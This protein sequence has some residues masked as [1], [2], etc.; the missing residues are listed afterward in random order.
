MAAWHVLGHT[1]GS[2]WPGRNI[3]PNWRRGHFIT[4]R[5]EGGVGDRP[6]ASLPGADAWHSRGKMA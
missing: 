6:G 1:L 3:W 2:R 5:P 4:V